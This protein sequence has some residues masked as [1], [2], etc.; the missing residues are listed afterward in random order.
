MVVCRNKNG[1]ISQCS[2]G[3]LPVRTYNFN[4]KVLSTGTSQQSNKLK[5]VLTFKLNSANSSTV[6]TTLFTNSLSNIYI[7]T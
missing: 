1:L 3:T 5:Q 4:K 2:T 6:A 7:R